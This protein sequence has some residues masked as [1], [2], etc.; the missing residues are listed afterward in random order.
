MSPDA[1]KK[2]PV[3]LS[4]EYEIVAQKCSARQMKPIA[5]GG[6]TP[7]T[8]ACTSSKSRHAASLTILYV[9]AYIIVRSPAANQME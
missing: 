5:F 2:L 8:L 7:L 6:K 1:L 3:T 9:L 4:Y